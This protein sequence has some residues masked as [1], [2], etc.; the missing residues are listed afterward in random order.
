MRQLAILLLSLLLT[1]PA[2]GAFADVGALLTDNS[3]G[4]QSTW[5]P[6][7]SAAL[8]VGNVG[9]CVLAVDNINTVGGE[10]SDHTTVTDAAGNTW[11]KRVESSNAANATA[12]CTV[13]IWTTVADF[14]LA[15]GGA[16]TFNIVS[17]RNKWTVTCREFSVSVG[18]ELTERDQT[19]EEQDNTDPGSIS[20]GTVA[21]IEHLWIHGMCG[22][23][24]DTV[25]TADGSATAFDF[26]SST[27]TGGGS[28]GNMAAR[29][30]FR[31]LNA[32]SYTGGHDPAWADAPDFARA[33]LAFEETTAPTGL[34][35]DMRIIN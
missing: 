19:L 14:E 33:L 18:D 8:E 20:S 4:Q 16:I 1:S 9:V 7:T 25:Y 10:T 27:T 24:N 15:S 13:S 23:T 21:G 17:N 30:D 26:S 34:V 29:A 5:A 35:N 31:I 3:S 6:T 2:W 32:T 22:E 11:T 12:S 28:A